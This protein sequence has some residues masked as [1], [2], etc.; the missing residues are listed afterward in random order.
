[1]K[2]FSFLQK[3]ENVH[4]LTNVTSL[5]FGKNKITKIENLETLTNLKTLSVQVSVFWRLE[6]SIL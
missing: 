1:M 5:Y 3:I 2:N 6:I 4:M